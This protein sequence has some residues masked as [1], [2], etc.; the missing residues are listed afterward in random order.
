MPVYY[1][2]E[3]KPYVFDLL[4]STIV[5]I[6]GLRLFEKD[7]WPISDTVWIGITLVLASCFAMAAPMIIGG[8]GGL[9][10]LKAL[11]ERRW[12]SVTVLAVSAVI[13]GIIYAVP[14]LSAFQTQIDQSGLDQG[15]VG[16]YFNRHFAPFPPTSLGDL[17]WYIE[18]VQDTLTPMVGRESNFAYVVLM[19]FGAI[20][21]ARQSMWKVAF[22]LAP[23]LVGLA[24][25][26][27]QVYPIMARLSLYVYPIALLLAAFA[28]EKIISE[29][30]RRANWV[31]FAAI[32][33]LSIGSVT[34]HRYY[35][36]FNPSVSP[37]DISTEMQTVAENIR[38]DEILVVSA[39]S[40]PAFLLYRHAFQLDQVNWTVAD[41]TACFFEPPIDLETRGRVWYLRGPFD[42]P[43][44]NRDASTYDLI[45]GQSPKRIDV[46]TIDA[47][48]DRLIVAAADI[49]AEGHTGCPIRPVEENLL[50][51]GRPPLHGTP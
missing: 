35:N 11:M 3:I 51:G 34:W 49:P 6:Q 13:A 28:L 8:F 26:A 22:I 30:P 40:L 14:A 17:A 9:L 48:L 10:G 29:L 47:R 38:P 20:I 36:T 23:I 18:I 24:L 31:V 27:A 5:L 12:G 39:W 2:A 7:D 50:M 44:P 21:V 41:R 4:F 42:G 16:H 19:I 1:S 15:G 45:L 32:L 37:K 43:G 25:S 33:L 46:K